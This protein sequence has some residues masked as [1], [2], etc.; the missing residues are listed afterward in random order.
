MK[1]HWFALIIALLTLGCRDDDV[2]QDTPSADPIEF[3]VA[4]NSGGCSN[5]QFYHYSDDRTYGLLLSGD[6]A[7][8]G[9]STGW[10]TYALDQPGMSL[11]LHEFRQPL[12]SYFCDDVVEANE[13]PLEIWD[14][15]EGSVQIK[16]SGPGQI[17]GRYAIDVVLENV[18]VNGRRLDRIARNGIEVGW[19]PS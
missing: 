14:A 17:L 19:V 4:A 18:L 16:I 7:Q 9:L 12:T 3:T 11:T 5:F 10:Q 6:S 13:D 2:G 8:L 15:Q 1:H